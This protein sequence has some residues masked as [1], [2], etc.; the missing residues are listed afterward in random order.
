MS[1]PNELTEIVELIL[2][3]DLEQAEYHLLIEST[4]ER[5]IQALDGERMPMDYMLKFE[6]FLDEHDIY[7]FDGWDTAQ[8]V[9][10]PRIEKYWAFFYLK[11]SK[12]TDLRGALRIQNSKEGQNKVG[13]KKTGDG[14]IFEFKILKRYL[15]Q[16]DQK[17]KEEASRVAGDE[18]EQIGQS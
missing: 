6:Q 7:L 16:L 17:N 2:E 14:Y 1:I 15:D 13:V 4:E 9:T 18:F 8:F 10:K 5:I 3:E 12:D 11:A